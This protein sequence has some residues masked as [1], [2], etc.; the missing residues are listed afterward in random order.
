MNTLRCYEFRLGGLSVVDTEFRSAVDT[1][2]HDPWR[3]SPSGRCRIG[4]RIREA[5][6][7]FDTLFGFQLLPTYLDESRHACGIDS[8]TVSDEVIIGSQL[9]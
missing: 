2:F 3:H 9:P 8:E 7:L 5:D 6:P 1:G 4:I